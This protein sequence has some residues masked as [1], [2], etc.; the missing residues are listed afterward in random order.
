[1]ITASDNAER[2]PAVIEIVGKLE[3][4]NM[5]ITVWSDI[6]QIEKIK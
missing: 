2:P 6:W 4:W 5:L 3:F 1:M